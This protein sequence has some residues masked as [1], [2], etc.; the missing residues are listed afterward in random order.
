MIGILL[1]NLGTPA[2]PTPQAVRRYLAEFLSDRRVVEIPT[3]LWWLLLHGFV[4]RT[5][6]KHSA[7]LYQQIWTEQGSPLLVH[8][9]ELAHQLQQR[10]KEHKVVLAMRYGEPSIAAGLKQLQTAGV[11]TLLVLPLYPQYSSATVGSTFNAVSRVLQTWRYLPKL[12]FINGYFDHP[13]YIQMLADQIKHYW[14]QNPQGE[15]LLFSFHGLREKTIQLGDP[16]YDQCRQ[17]AQ[18]IAHTLGLSAHQW[19]TV[20]Q[21]RFG[22]TEWLKPYCEQTLQQL[23]KQGIKRVDIVCPGFAVDCLETLEEI[24]LRNKTTF[25]QAG[26]QVYDYIPALNDSEAHISYLMT[27]IK[28]NL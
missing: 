6:P 20:F 13:L 3:P 14:Q 21:S 4:L 24:A 25:L 22:R 7:K 27:L 17:T 1:T 19:L 9:T 12:N 28:Q 26:G 8:S 11:T 15:K 2:A 16:Y 18:L 5:R 10:L 23:A